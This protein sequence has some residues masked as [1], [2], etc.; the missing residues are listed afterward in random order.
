MMPPSNSFLA[1][2][3]STIS[4]K[5]QSGVI[6]MMYL[7][8]LLLSGHSNCKD[9]IS[10]MKKN[11]RWSTKKDGQT[12]DTAGEINSRHLHSYEDWYILSMIVA[13]AS[14]A[15]YGNDPL[16]HL[17][18][19]VNDLTS[20]VLT[21]ANVNYLFEAAVQLKCHR[22]VEKHQNDT[23]NLY[24]LSELAQQAIR[25]KATSAKWNLAGTK[26]SIV[27]TDDLLEAIG[28]PE[29]INMNMTR[30]FLSQ[31][32]A[33]AAAA[34]PASN[35]RNVTS[36][37]RSVSA[38]TRPVL[39]LT[40]QENAMRNDNTP[41]GSSSSSTVQSLTSSPKKVRP[42]RARRGAAA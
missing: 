5:Y 1:K 41:S 27:I 6:G 23:K 33:K 14:S 21:E 7:A 13:A 38:R 30:S 28:D 15:L 24:V 31:V 3:S 11:D 42:V 12:P 25:A 37:F 26:H 29:A 40:D 39:D 8:L 22:F 16:D 2:I 18:I 17:R 32:M 34:N 9:S 10:I 19:L 4:R 35:D 20:L 36:M